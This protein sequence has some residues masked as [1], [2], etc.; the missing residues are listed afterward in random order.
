VGLVWL[1]RHLRNERIHPAAIPD[2]Y[3]FENFSKERLQE[4]LAFEKEFAVL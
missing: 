2:S 3:R 1:V 4:R